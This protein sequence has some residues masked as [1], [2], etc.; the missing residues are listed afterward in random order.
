MRNAVDDDLITKSPCKVIGAGTEH[1]AERPI[2]TVAEIAALSQA[3]PARLQ[4][5]VELASWCQLRRGEILG[6]RRSD[7]DLMHATIRIERSRTFKRDGSSLTKSPK[8]SS[9][10]RSLSIPSN[11]LKTLE[12][13]LNDFTG[14]DKD[15][16]LDS[17]G[18]PVRKLPESPVWFNLA[19][20]TRRN[21]SGAR[22]RHQTCWHSGPTRALSDE[23]VIMYGLETQQMLN[24]KLEFRQLVGLRVS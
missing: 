9:G 1:A 18:T 4:L 10:R 15:A 5:L 13:H 11:V 7:V 22:Y 17:I 12:I 8:T 6:L 14:G 24:S 21:R 20:E 23:D 16:L 3:M 2:A 19:P